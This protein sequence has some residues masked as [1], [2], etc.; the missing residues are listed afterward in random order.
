[1]IRHAIIFA[2]VVLA[3]TNH[4]P[5]LVPIPP[6]LRPYVHRIVA[7]P[8]YLTWLKAHSDT[9][10]PLGDAIEDKSLSMALR[11]RLWQAREKLK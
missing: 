11:Q 7:E 9:Q 10:R 3:R 2:A 4:A 5:V 1:M 8:E 6:E